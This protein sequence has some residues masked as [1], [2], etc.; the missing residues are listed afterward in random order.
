MTLLFEMTARVTAIILLSLVCA[1][2][3]RRRAAAVRH[4]TL[5]AGLL[6]AAAMP[7]LQV[8][9]PAW[10][11]PRASVHTLVS[12][13]AATV[14]VPPPSATVTEPVRL[15]TIAEHPS[16]LFRLVGVVWIVGGLIGLVL[17]CA[18][19]V[20]LT[21]MT[22]RCE[23]VI[24]PRWTEPLKAI[25]THLRLRRDVVLLQSEHDRLLVTSGFWRPKIILPL[26]ATAWTADRIRMVLCHELSHI[27]R[28]DPMLQIL[29]GCVRSVYW[30]NPLVWTACYWLRH[31]S[32]RACDDDVLSLG[33]N[34]PDYA[35]ELLNIARVLRPVVWSPAPGMARPSSLQ[36]R[37]CAMLDANIDRRPLSSARRAAIAA[38]TLL[39]AVAIA[40]SGAA[41]QA[42]GATFSG[43]FVDALNNAVPNVTLTLRSNATGERYTARSDDGGRFVFNALPDGDYEGE[44]SAVGFASIHPFFRIK[45][46]ESVQPKVIALPLGTVEETITVKD[47]AAVGSPI[48][49]LA[50]DRLAALRL[51]AHAMPLAPPIKTR[52]VR[53][54]FPP[55]RSGHDATIFLG[56][57][58]DTSGNIR[59]LDVMQPADAE[60]GRAAFDAVKEWQFE[61]T[62]LHGVPVDTSMHVTVRFVH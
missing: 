31:E 13:A 36:R 45:D 53:P 28:G 44:V 29:A 32:E 38:S 20:R 51:K 58:I 62:R 10:G 6:C 40:G 19:L 49:A 61:P 30:F 26:S 34:G 56:A 55:S 22:A 43:A 52:D 21:W 25:A 48:P 16:T 37:V 11:V 7:L 5:A 46:G 39:A 9:T 15:T 17:V 2:F 33:M 60:F 3:M 59:G 14:A 47:E 18:G 1:A 12:R 35:T 54:L 41:A 27:R 8:V 57:V 23:P 4:W 50:P 42:V 24:D